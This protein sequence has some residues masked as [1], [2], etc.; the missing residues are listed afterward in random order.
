MNYLLIICIIL[1]I[2]DISMNIVFKIMDRKP[3]KESKPKNDSKEK[4]FNEDEYIN[5]IEFNRKLDDMIVPLIGKYSNE[6]IVKI[7]TSNIIKKET[8]NINREKL[9]DYVRHSLSFYNNNYTDSIDEEIP[10]P[11]NRYEDSGRSLNSREVDISD[12]MRNFYE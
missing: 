7:I 4:D 5:S 3:V 9:I 8:H 12:T 10:N 6:N 11:M 1:S 2:I